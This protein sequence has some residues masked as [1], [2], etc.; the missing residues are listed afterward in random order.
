MSNRR[1]AVTPLEL[2]A[3]CLIVCLLLFGLIPDALAQEPTDWQVELSFDPFTEDQQI[4]ITKESQSH[5]P[6]HWPQ[7]LV[8]RCNA[9]DLEFGVS[10]GNYV[11]YTGESLHDVQYRIDDGRIKTNHWGNYGGQMLLRHWNRGFGKRSF[12]KWFEDI[13]NAETFSTRIEGVDGLLISAQWDMT[14]FNSVIE[15]TGVMECAEL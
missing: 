3:L 7:T 12:L 5:E 8:F 9:G 1:S 13:R 2:V 4:I 14:G 11:T 6:A 15:A 10:Y